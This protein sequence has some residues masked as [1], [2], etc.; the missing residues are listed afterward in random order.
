MTTATSADA[1]LEVACDESGSEGERL[2]GGN[3]DVFA[4]AGVRLDASTAAEAI[5]EIRDRIRSPATEYKAN[6]LLR[7]KHRSVLMWLL[8]ST[9]PIHDRAQVQLIEKPALLV[10]RVA[11]VLLGDPAAAAALYR[12]GPQLFGAWWQTFLEASNE[13]MRAKHRDDVESSVQALFDAIDHLAFVGPTPDGPA[14]LVALLRHCR[15]RTEAWR[16]SRAD[17]PTAMPVLDPLIPALV[18]TVAYWSADGVPVSIVHDEQNSLTD[19]RIVQLRQIIDGARGEPADPAASRR[20]SS[21]R[22]ADSR[23]DARVQLADF[24]AGVARRIAEDEL[25]GH[26]DAEL[27]ALLQPYVDATSTWGDNRSWSLLCRPASSASA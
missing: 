19:E 21:L 17:D 5:V 8:G 10:N 24:L 26:G 23:F 14:G 11:D 22:L 6:H 13:V 4:H 16:A 12:E 20:L 18:Q 1:A 25:N 2:I 3:T 9:G 15:P 27:T 7:E